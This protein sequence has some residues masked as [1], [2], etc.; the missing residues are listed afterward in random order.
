LFVEASGIAALVSYKSLGMEAG[1]MSVLKKLLFLFPL[2]SWF[3][4]S[5]GDIYIYLCSLFLWAH[6]TLFSWLLSLCNLILLPTVSFTWTFTMAIKYGIIGGL[7]L[8]AEQT[9]A[10]SW[11]LDN[12]AAVI[13]KF[14]PFKVLD[15]S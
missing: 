1:G 2:Y 13:G 12:K 9:S 15:E 8:L 7:A 3:Y 11:Q 10:L 6:W 5:F 4:K 14:S